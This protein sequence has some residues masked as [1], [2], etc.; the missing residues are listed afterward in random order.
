MS[1]PH[2]N[3]NYSLHYQL[4]RRFDGTQ[5]V[6]TLWRRDQSL[7]QPRIESQ[8][9]GHSAPSCHYTDCDITAESPLTVKDEYVMKWQNVL[10]P[11]KKETNYSSIVNCDLYVFILHQAGRQEVPN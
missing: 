4:D 6:R 11:H 10:Q 9:A 1:R 3:R 5:P 2:Y 8:F 7:F